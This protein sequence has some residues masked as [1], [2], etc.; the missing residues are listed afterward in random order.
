M[1]EGFFPPSPRWFW[2]WWGSPWCFCPKK[3]RACA[4]DAA[5]A[6]GYFS[7]WYLIF[8]NESYFESLG[9]PSLLASSLVARR[10]GAVLP[11]VATCRIGALLVRWRRSFSV[12][13]VLILAAASSLLMA[14][15][16]HQG[17]DPSRIYYGS[18]TRAAGLLIGAALAFVRLPGRPIVHRSAHRGQRSLSAQSRLAVRARLVLHLAR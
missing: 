14:L 16:Y 12:A 13:A 2:A 4:G 5:A 6:A 7:N 17:A 3:L 18:D 15:L 8:N 9:R 11:R 10:G 1:P